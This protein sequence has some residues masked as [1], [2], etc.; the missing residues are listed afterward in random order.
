MSANTPNMSLRSATIKGTRDRSAYARS[1]GATQSGA[2]G[3]GGRNR[4]QRETSSPYAATV[5]VG[6][7]DRLPGALAGSNESPAA[8]SFDTARASTHRRRHVS[9]PIWMRPGS[10]G[11]KGLAD[12]ALADAR[13]RD[14]RAPDEPADVVSDDRRRVMAVTF[15]AANCHSVRSC[16]ITAYL[17]PHVAT[18]VC[19]QAIAA[20]NRPRNTNLPDRTAEDSQ[21][22]A[23]EKVR[24]KE[25]PSDMPSFAPGVRESRSLS[26]QRGAPRRA[27][28]PDRTR[29][30][31]VLPSAR[32]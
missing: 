28:G 17:E 25:G 16:G 7:L 29:R 13:E 12:A 10:Q 1:T 23:T 11:R 5:T 14:R 32:N 27:C 15:R 21:G 30:R 9:T 31:P 6:W 22:R 19:A 3:P 8:P 2:A 24:L 18:I 26:V 20:H 4:T